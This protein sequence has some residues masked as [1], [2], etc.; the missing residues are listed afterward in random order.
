MY[1][2]E[3]SLCK[4]TLGNIMFP[5]PQKV[6]SSGYEGLSV[7]TIML[8]RVIEDL[9]CPSKT[10]YASELASLSEGDVWG[11]GSAWKSLRLWEPSPFLRYSI[12]AR[13]PREIRRSLTTE[14]IKT[15]RSMLSIKDTAPEFLESSEKKDL[16]RWVSQRKAGKAAFIITAYQTYI[17]AV[18]IDEVTHWR[19][20]QPLGRLLLRIPSLIQKA[21]PKKRGKCSHHYEITMNL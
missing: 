21:S 18:I 13:E 17:N 1:T 11:V 12:E 20:E 9:D 19:K 6:H 16:A 7:S 3:Q 2:S 10:Y 4:Q 15:Y 8:G 14:G 5:N